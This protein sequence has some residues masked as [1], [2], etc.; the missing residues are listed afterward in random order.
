M[1]FKKLTITDENIKLLQAIKF[2]SFVFDCAF[3]AIDDHQTRVV[4]VIGR[5][6]CQHFGRKRIAV[7]R[8][9]HIVFVSFVCCK[10]Q[11]ININNT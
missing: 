10:R 8:K 7:L 5:I 1:A 9:F 3:G 4:A 6:L 2:E 11:R